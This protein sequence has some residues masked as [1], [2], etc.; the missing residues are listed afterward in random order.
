MRLSL[1]DRLMHVIYPPLCIHCTQN[2]ASNRRS[3]CENCKDLLTFLNPQERCTLCFNVLENAGGL[4]CGH[5]RQEKSFFSGLGAAFE[6]YGPAATLI[7]ELKY[8]GRF[9]FAKDAAALML[10]Q[11][12][13]L[14]WPLPDLV[15]PVPQSFASWLRRGYNQSLLIAREFGLLIDRP[16]LDL[17]KKKSG[18]LSQTGLS[19]Q[20]RKALDPHMFAWKKTYPVSGM[21]LL[22]ID[23]VMTTSTTL[24]HSAGVLQ[25][26]FP[27]SL[28][29]LTFCIS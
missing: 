6:Y 21:T 12:T 27:K 23:D 22:L 24:R 3:F 5:C 16:V 2:T 14:N 29:G 8:S 19:R 20:Q 11:F 18:A 1:W 28:Y 26:G 4:I 17:L 7:R 15:V 9:R 25:E 13:K 10:V